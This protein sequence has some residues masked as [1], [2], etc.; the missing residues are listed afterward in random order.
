MTILQPAKN[1]NEYKRIKDALKERFETE[2]SGDQYLFR[3]QSKM[4]QPLIKSLISTQEQTVKAIQNSGTQDLARELQRRTDQVDL[5]VQQPFYSD[6]LPSIT[7][8]KTSSPM[9]DY[10]K[11]NFDSD[12][13]ETDFLEN[14]QDMSFDMP[15]KVVKN[16]QIEETLDTIKTENSSQN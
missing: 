7:A 10:I 12:L 2:R 16:K 6:Q 5:L 9:K 1:I 13:N 4:L 14:L 11:I 3:E 15:S 8:P